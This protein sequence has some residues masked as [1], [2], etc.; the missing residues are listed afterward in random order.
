MAATVY[1]VMHN[2]CSHDMFVP[3]WAKDGNPT[4]FGV[5]STREE[6]EKHIRPN[7]DDYI[8][9]REVDEND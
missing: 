5:Y 8:I 1:I 7:M 4:F 2:F 3:Q 9:E 6:A